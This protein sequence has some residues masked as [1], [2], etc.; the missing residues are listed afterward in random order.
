MNKTRTVSQENLNESWFLV[1]AKGQRVGRI[2]GVISQL[3]LAKNNVNTRA[4]LM[5]KNK[6]VVINAAEV[7]VTPKRADTK[8]YTQYSGYQGGITYTFLKDMLQKF[9]TRVLENAISGMMPKNNRA[10][11][12]MANNLFVFAGAEHKHEAQQPVIVDVNN[13]KI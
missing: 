8:F 3:L 4:Y 2:A 9:P 11:H 13:F 1:D 6:V 7:D 12:I 5:P 10:K